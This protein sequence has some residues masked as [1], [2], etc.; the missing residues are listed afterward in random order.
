MPRK[1]LI[2]GGQRFMGRAV[3]EALLQAGDDV[4]L[5]SRGKTKDPFGDRVKRIAADRDN[6]PQM[7]AA[8]E[9]FGPCDVMMDFSARD[10]PVHKVADVV[11]TMHG[12]VGHFIFISTQAV[13]Q[14][15]GWDPRKPQEEEATFDM[16]PPDEKRRTAY[17]WDKAAAE[18]LLKAAYTVGG[19]PSTRIRIPIVNGPHDPTFRL[20]RYHA[21]LKSGHPV[22]VTR[23]G[24]KAYSTVYSEDV[25]DAIMKILDKGKPTFGEVYQLNQSERPTIAEV[26]EAMAA[27][28]AYPAPKGGQRV[29]VLTDAQVKAM[30]AKDRQKLLSWSHLDGMDQTMSIE[31]AR[32][33]LGWEPTPM[34][35]W[36]AKTVEWYQ[37]GESD[38]TLTGTVPAPF[39]DEALMD[40]MDKLYHSNPS[41]KL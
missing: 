26:A 1:C 10:T 22:Y 15:P 35:V 41:S 29:R 23:G 16:S 38:R 30:D 3:V 40:R 2:L 7:R 4:T 11:N 27:T 25:V 39:V 28:G 37:T 21:W 20:W 13:Y 9:K 19:F 32:H 12:K 14:S 31:K 17:G 34:S 24:N 33:E 6:R 36:Y 18:E 5:L 8:L